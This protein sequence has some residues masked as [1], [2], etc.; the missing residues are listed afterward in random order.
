MLP[1][2]SP[3]PVINIQFYL[4]Q[5]LEQFS[6]IKSWK[7][8]STLFSTGLIN[9]ISFYYFFL[10]FSRYR[11]V[12]LYVPNTD[13]RSKR[14]EEIRVPNS[15]EGRETITIFSNG[16]VVVPLK[17]VWK[18]NR[19]ERKKERNRGKTLYRGGAANSRP[20]K[21]PRAFSELSSFRSRCTYAALPLPFFSLTYTRLFARQIR[22]TTCPVYPI[23][24][25]TTRTRS[26]R[27]RSA[28]RTTR[29]WSR[30]TRLRTAGGGGSS[31]R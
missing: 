6:Y 12:C 30:D 2:R 7:N 5:A 28:C 26:R 27:S 10:L 17:R 15:K 16:H 21:F 4:S 19:D 1:L 20:L 18:N 31:A 14:R 9:L 22:L 13:L 8:V 3:R 25:T 23:R 29:A 11:I 24:R